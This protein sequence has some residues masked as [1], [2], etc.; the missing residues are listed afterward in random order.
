M[1]FTHELESIN[2]A[3]LNGAFDVAEK[4]WS[5]LKPVTPAEQRTKAHYEGILAF[6]RGKVAL[7]K[8][9][10]ESAVR[11]YGENVN[12]LRDLVICQYHLRDM[13]GFRT[14]LETL[15]QRLQNLNAK[16][17]ARSLFECNVMVGKFLEEEARLA[18]AQECYSQALR[19]AQNPRQR[20]RALI[21]KARWCA[22]YQPVGALSA[23]YRELISVG[24]EQMTRDLHIELEHSLMLIEIRLVGVDHAWQRVLPLLADTDDMDRRLLVFDYAEGV[25]ALD[26]DL[27][28]DVLRIMNEFTELDPFESL[29][30]KLAQE[31]LEPDAKIQ[32]LTLLATQVPWASY[33]RLLCLATNKET[34]TNVRQELNRKIQLIVRSLDPTSQTLWNQRLKQQLQAPE[35]RLEYS[36]RQ[37][38]L[39]VQGRNVDLSKKKISLQLLGGLAG[40]PELSVDEAIALLWQSDFSPEHYHRLRMGVHRLNSLINKVT[41]LGKVIEV[42]SQTVRLRPEVRLKLVDEAF[43]GE[44]LDL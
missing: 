36:T 41:G 28:E 9:L 38:S 13:S 34:S 3:I 24:K 31:T 33:L 35:V 10:F 21:Q 26:L 12:L 15:E 4:A 30:R 7:A 1:N 18:P 14:N 5:A 43:S 22:L 27:D 2:F 6:Q 29:I 23:L 40:K 17:S 39:A 11:G 32:A 16:L 20:L 42:D 37:R 8:Q 19:H 44:L 25:L